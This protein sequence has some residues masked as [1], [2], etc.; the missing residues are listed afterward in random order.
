M[1]G[2]FL[3]RIRRAWD[4]RAGRFVW[5][6]APMPFRWG[7]PSAQAGYDWRKAER[8]AALQNAKAIRLVP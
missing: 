2:A 6:V 5:E 7:G 3:P 1:S 8:W 4:A